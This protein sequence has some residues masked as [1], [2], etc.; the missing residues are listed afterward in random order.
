MPIRGRYCVSC[1]HGGDKCIIPKWERWVCPPPPLSLSRVCACVRAC[2]RAC[3]YVCVYVLARARLCNNIR[4]LSH[5]SFVPSHDTILFS[6]VLDMPLYKCAHTYTYTHNCT[7]AMFI[8]LF[9]C[10]LSSLES[11][12]VMRRA[13]GHVPDCRSRSTP[14]RRVWR[15]PHV[16]SR[17]R[18]R[19]VALRCV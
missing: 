10:T 14:P 7:F 8:I 17:W 2:V 5:A 18:H 12:L 1:L 16:A 19:A 6:I 3:V 11:T 9:G 15:H 13:L 4:P